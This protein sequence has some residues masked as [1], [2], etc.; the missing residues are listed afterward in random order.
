MLVEFKVA[1]Y[2]SFT[3]E[4]QTLSMVANTDT[5]FRKEN[6]FNPPGNFD[7]PLV[8]SAVLYGPNASGK[9]SLISALACMRNMVVSSATH[10]PEG[11]ELDIV[12]FRLDAHTI[13]QPTTFEI[14][15][16]EDG[17][18]YQYGFSATNT[19]IMEE[20][21]FAFPKAKGQRWFFRQYNTETCQDEW[22]YSSHLKGPRHL[23]EQ[24]TRSNALFLSTAVNLNSEQ[25][26]PV[27]NWFSHQLIL[28]EYNMPLNMGLTINMLRDDKERVMQLLQEADLGIKNIDV[29]EKK[30]F[31]L[32]MTSENGKQAIKPEEVMIPEI[33]FYH[34]C[35]NS[36]ELVGLDFYEESEGTKRVAAYAGYFL[37]MMK[38]N[39]V[40]VVDEMSSSLHPHLMRFL[41][42]LFHN[43]A[44]NVANSQ[45]FFTT[46]DT[47]LLDSNVFRRDQIWFLEKN[48]EQASQ[49]YPLTDFSPRKD[50]ALGKGYLKGR[51]GAIPFIGEL[52]V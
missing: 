5:L 13:K 31:R 4:A 36:T 30:V 48:Q 23:W 45:L 9:S 25:L 41:L 20:W 19:Q 43:S 10:I 12:P 40:L 46:H 8:R 32:A 26:R 38:R 17:I 16:I 6:C 39:C 42:G 24:S 51:Y 37:Q 29:K 27:F 7:L 18:R 49:L 2:K 3:E 44:L 15:F 11:Q 35:K 1:N 21:L 28:I 22:H 50:E 47:T 33:K 14:I 34:T 52:E